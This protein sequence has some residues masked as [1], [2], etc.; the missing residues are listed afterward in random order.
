MDRM[1][2]HPPRPFLIV[3][4]KMGFAKISERE[5]HDQK[6]SWITLLFAQESRQKSNNT[7]L[8]SVSLVSEGV[9]PKQEKRRRERKL[10][11]HSLSSQIN[12]Q[13]AAILLFK[14]F[15]NLKDPKIQVTVRRFD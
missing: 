7:D 4:G 6:H 15:Y 10:L 2:H 5:A 14:I 11:L 8:L 12:D 3:L 9:L 13:L 1:L